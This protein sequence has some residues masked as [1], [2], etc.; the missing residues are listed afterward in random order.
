[1]CQGHVLKGGDIGTQGNHLTSNYSLNAL[2]W[3]AH[4]V[5]QE[6]ILSFTRIFKIEEASGQNNILQGTADKHLK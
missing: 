5:L 6:A 2:Q 4:V 3:K 1:M